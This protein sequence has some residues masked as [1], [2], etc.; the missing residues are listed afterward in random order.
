[1]GGVLVLQFIDDEQIAHMEE[2]IREK[3]YLEG[4]HLAGMFNLMRENDLIWS[5]VVNN[6]LLGKDP[7]PFDLL[8]WNQDS[9]RMAAA[10]HNFY[11]SEFY[12]KNS[13]AEGKLVLGFHLDLDTAGGDA[14][15]WGYP[16][17]TMRGIP[18]LRYQNETAGVL[19]T[20]LRWDFLE[21]W[22][23]VGFVGNDEIEVS[24]D[25]RL[26]QHII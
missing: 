11:L 1:M 8:Y 24:W 9:T 20:E 22:A 17:I 19:E 16:W 14:P 6:Y 4:H 12:A 10:N 15:I 25:G 13:L 23:A 26:G 2:H 5:F 7:F 3:G 18:A 21:R